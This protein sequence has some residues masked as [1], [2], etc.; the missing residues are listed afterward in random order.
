MFYYIILCYNVQLC[1]GCSI[2]YS[3]RFV[4]F[5]RLLYFIWKE[6]LFGWCFEVCLKKKQKKKNNVQIKR[7]VAH[8]VV[9]INASFYF[10]NK[11]TWSELPHPNLSFVPFFTTLLGLLKY[12]SWNF[13]FFFARIVWKLPL[14]CLFLLNLTCV[15]FTI[16]L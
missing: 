10:H 14:N 7:F 5:L 2:S 6:S 11:E 12:K 3:P 15:Y 9:S 1:F 8:S 13:L 16:D 4:L